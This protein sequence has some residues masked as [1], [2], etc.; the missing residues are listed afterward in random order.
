MK[1]RF[2]SDIEELN[3]KNKEK[4]NFEIEKQTT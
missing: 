3:N 2:E 4:F 1:K